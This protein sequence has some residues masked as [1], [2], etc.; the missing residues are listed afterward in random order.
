MPNAQSGTVRLERVGKRNKTAVLALK[1][2]DDQTDLV[3]SNAESLAEAADDEDARPR[4][5]LANGSVVGFLMYDAT[6]AEALLYRFMID[7][8][9]QGKGYGRGALSAVLEEITALSHVRDIV[10]G[11]M[12]ENTGARHLYRTAGFVEEKKDEDGE[13]LARLS[14]RRR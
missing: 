5:I 7:R 2:A 12:P 4:A 3:A 10:V 6:D 1:L 13:M 8:A 9:E 11:Y 14:V